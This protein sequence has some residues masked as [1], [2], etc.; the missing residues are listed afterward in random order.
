MDEK[1]TKDP[2]L[3][4]QK[5]LL[6]IARVIQIAAWVIATGFVLKLF[7]D[8]S[9]TLQYQ[10][11]SAAVEGGLM[12]EYIWLVITDHLMTILRGA[13]FWLVLIGIS[14]GLKLVVETDKNYRKK[15]SEQ[16]GSPSGESEEVSIPTYYD[17]NLVLKLSDWMSNAA[18]ISIILSVLM[19]L[20]AIR[21]THPVVLSFF[22]GN[23]ELVGLAWVITVV[24]FL[25]GAALESIVLYFFF[26]SMGTILL[27]LMEMEFNSR[28]RPS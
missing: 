7:G 2:V 16:D 8:L 15:E 14:A 24:I 1:T 17:P 5:G 27:V 12:F 11:L 9:L 6:R 22:H 21:T 26:K 10:S 20:V 23:P 13:G 28:K 19:N 4:D 3:P 18:I 25:V